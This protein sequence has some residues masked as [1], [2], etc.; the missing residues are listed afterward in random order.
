MKPHK[1]YTPSWA[2]KPN[3][4]AAKFAALKKQQRDEKQAAEHEL[5]RQRMTA[6]DFNV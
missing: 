5:H 2:M 3:Y 4:L 6:G 1:P